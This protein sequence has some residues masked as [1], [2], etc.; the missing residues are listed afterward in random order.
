MTV[1][2]QGYEGCFHQI[3]AENYFGKREVEI[4]PCDSFSKLVKLVA[5]KKVD[6]GVMAI[7]NS[8]AGSIL[9]NYTLLQKSNLNVIGEI[10][11][12]IRQ[13]LMVMPG[14]ALND[15]KEVHSHPMA[16]L[17]CSDYLEKRPEWRLVETEDTALSAKHV[18]QYKALHIA[19]IASR[20][21]AEL[22]N[23]EVIAPNIHTMKKNYTRFLVLNHQ[24][25]T[26]E[27]QQPNKS[28]LY[29]QA[30]HVHGSLAKVLCCIADG[31][32][33]LSKLQSFPIPGSEWHYYFHADMEYESLE[34]FYDVLDAL[35]PLT[36]SLKILGN[37]KKGI[38][39]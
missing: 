24:H 7:E 11:L 13:H 14:R 16:L 21:A 19:A 18:R 36:E 39:L 2:I 23:L 22:Y 25:N 4:V 12:T 5:Q 37:Y 8:L 30:P 20:R 9:P 10:Y 27:E 29:F 35:K 32:V 33:N 38:T 31:G 34:Q 17:Q 1:A 28:S 3:A 26:I 6:A 15:I